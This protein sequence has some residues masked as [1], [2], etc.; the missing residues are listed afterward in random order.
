MLRPSPHSKRRA[1]CGRH[2]P[3]DRARAEGRRRAETAGGGPNLGWPAITCGKR[4][5]GQSVGSDDAAK[6]GMEQP[7]CFRDPVTAP[8]GTA[9]T[10]GETFAD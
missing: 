9:F 6:E 3:G 8:G 2:A 7:I 5:P 10:S 1:G 4:Y